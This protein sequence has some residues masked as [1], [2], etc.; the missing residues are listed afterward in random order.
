[1]LKN[2]LPSVRH[3][4][5]AWDGS[6]NPDHLAGEQIPVGAR[7]V[8]LVEQLEEVRFSNLAES[9]VAAL[10]KQMAVNGSGTK[11]APAV[12]DAFL[13]LPSSPSPFK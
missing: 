12:V 1:M 4:H 3:H 7:I 13:S 10:Q 2:V 9:D 11:F 8:G 6:G 5:V